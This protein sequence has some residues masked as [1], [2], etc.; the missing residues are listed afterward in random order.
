MFR[1]TFTGVSSSFL[2][3]LSFAWSAYTG[4]YLLT[5]K[6]QYLLHAEADTGT[7][8]APLAG[9]FLFRGLGQVV[10]VLLAELTADF[11]VLP[12]EACAAVRRTVGMVSQTV[13]DNDIV[14]APRKPP[15]PK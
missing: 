7:V 3:R 10:A 4:R 15:Y 11:S 8:A 2:H 9:A 12:K 13:D 5:L 6:A 1:S 14:F